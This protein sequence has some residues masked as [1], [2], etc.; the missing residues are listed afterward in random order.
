MSETE[1]EQSA[2]GNFTNAQTGSKIKTQ[3]F[4]GIHLLTHI[5]T[6]ALLVGDLLH[7]VDTNCINLLCA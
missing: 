7:H 4:D 6:L 3:R 2:I 5:P 1:V